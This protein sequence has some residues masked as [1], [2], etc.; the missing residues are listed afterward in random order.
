MKSKKLSKIRLARERKRLFQVELSA[1]C[2][3]SQQFISLVENGKRIP[4]K[5]L[6]NK[7][8][9]ALETDVETIFPEEG[10]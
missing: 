6:K 2:G 10:E 1:L 5:K 9:A 3:C 4:S 8:A 7:I